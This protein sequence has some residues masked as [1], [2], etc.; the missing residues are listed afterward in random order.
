MIE[1]L[2]SWFIC[3]I[4]IAITIAIIDE[5]IGYKL[6]EKPNLLL[7]LAFIV[8]TLIE[9]ASVTYTGKPFIWLIFNWPLPTP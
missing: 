7:F 2:I 5:S 6:E 9:L 8:P 3:F 4:S 1:T